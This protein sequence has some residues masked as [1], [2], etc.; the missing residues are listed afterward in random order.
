[1]IL[2]LLVNLQARGLN[3]SYDSLN[4]LNSATIDGSYVEYVYDKAGNLLETKT[5][6]TI[7][8]TVM[9]AGTV[10]DNRNKIDCGEDCVG[11]YGNNTSVT[12]TAT[13]DAGNI[14]TGWSGSGCSG[15]STCTINVT[16]QH[17]VQATFSGTSGNNAP[18][19]T[20]TGPFNIDENSSNGSFVGNID[21]HDGDGG[22]TDAGLA[23]SITGGTGQSVFTVSNTGVLTVANSTALNYEADMSFSLTVNVYDG[24]F[25]TSANITINVNNLTEISAPVITVPSIGST[26]NTTTPQLQGTGQAGATVSVIGPQSQSCSGI[27]AGN[28]FWSCT[29]S[30]GL[31][32]GSNTLYAS[33]VSSGGQTSPTTSVTFTVNG[34]ISEPAPVILSPDDNAIIAGNNVTV[35][36]TSEPGIGL[37]VS[38]YDG[39]VLVNHYCEAIYITGEWS[40]PI[41]ALPYGVYTVNAYHYSTVSG[42]TISPAASITVNL[43]DPV[44]DTIFK[45][46]FD[47]PVDPA[48]ISE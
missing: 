28:G 38:V 36:G 23:Y 20:A 18:I 44:L 19:F 8:V 26:V 6:H 35:S 25:N 47:E 3:Y 21:A 37:K 16:V 22:A 2:C 11:V 7:S 39:A 40:C 32:Q 12:L 10:T 42:V 5:P 33:Q 41:T 24:S 45:D 30:S 13:P 29:L 34:M 9:G 15:T 31:Q 48:L 1:M 43:I 46:G 4:R 17:T 27:V 14:F